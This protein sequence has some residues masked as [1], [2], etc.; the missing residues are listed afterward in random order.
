MSVPVALYKVTHYFFQDSLSKKNEEIYRCQQVDAF[1]R[2]SV[3]P[4]N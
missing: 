3:V 1:V 2:S 4:D